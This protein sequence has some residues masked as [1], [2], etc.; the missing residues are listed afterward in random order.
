MVELGDDHLTWKSATFHLKLISGS[1]LT[2]G[3]SGLKSYLNYLILITHAICTC[4]IGL[5]KV[6]NLKNPNFFAIFQNFDD[7]IYPIFKPT[8]FEHA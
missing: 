3:V 1:F 6:P 4:K 7:E 8:C 2:T 5:T